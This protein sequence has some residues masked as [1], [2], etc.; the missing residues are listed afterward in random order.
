M[1]AALIVAIVFAI[2]GAEIA[3][4]ILIER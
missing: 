2:L 3:V 4:C 1:T